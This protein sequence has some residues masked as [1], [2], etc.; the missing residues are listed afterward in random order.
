MLTFQNASMDLL[1]S[2]SPESPSTEVV[3]HAG[4][5]NSTANSAPIGTALRV[6]HLS[7]WCRQSAAQAISLGASSCSQSPDDV[8][9]L[10][11]SFR[12]DSRLYS[13]TGSG[14]IRRPAALGLLL[15]CA[16]YGFRF[17]PKQIRSKNDTERLANFF[18]SPPKKQT[19]GTWEPGPLPRLRHVCP[20]S[21]REFKT[22][23]QTCI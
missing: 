6:S 4:V 13:G 11:A 5:S 10:Y 22:E 21:I 23:K 1:I 16:P 8:F 12:L 17:L 18:W 3:A 19:F 15:R 7:S 20:E 14:H 2:S 9:C